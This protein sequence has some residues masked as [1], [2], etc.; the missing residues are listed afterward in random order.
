MARLLG[1]AGMVTLTFVLLWML[2]DASFRVSEANVTVSGL[3]HADEAEVRAL[4]A[5]LERSPNAFRVRASEIVGRLQEL[6]AVIAAT[7][8][9]HLPDSV[10]IQVQERQPLFVWSD[11]TSRLLVDDEGV[12]FA[13]ADAEEPGLPVVEDDR[14]PA[15]PLQMGSRLPAPDLAVMRQLLAL[16]PERLN[17]SAERL[18]LRVD[19]QDG[20]VLESELDWQAVF[21][22][23]TATLQPPSVVPRQ[24]Q[25]LSWLLA[26]HERTL[27]RTYLAVSESACGTMQEV[28]RPR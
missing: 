18:E 23:Y 14:L 6:P 22:H 5:G 13:A 16:T 26:A 10:A 3:V 28:R 15:T 4:L 1:A 17:S 8:Q 24:V 20:Y 7:A 2:T 21:G 25:C 11:G 19:E 12:L 27:V 9:V